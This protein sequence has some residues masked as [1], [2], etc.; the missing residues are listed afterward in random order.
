[1]GIVKLSNF[2][3]RPYRIPAQSESKDLE[4]FIAQTETAALKRLLGIK[5]YDE[6][7]AGLA[8]DPVPDKWQDLKDG[9]EYVFSTVT[10]K[11]EGLVDLLVPHIFS[12]WLAEVSDKFTNSG[13]VRNKVDNSDLVNAAT[14][15][16]KAQMVYYNKAGDSLRQE[17]TLFGFLFANSADY[18]DA[19]FTCPERM[20]EFGI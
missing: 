14:R 10:Y 2:E 18:D 6:L 9:E 8:L 3:V 1:M 17:N 15:I 16:A 13:V 4:D 20:N 19:V 5:L 11:Y 12:K 7:I